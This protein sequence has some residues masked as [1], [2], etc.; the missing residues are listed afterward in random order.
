MNRN[1]RSR[2]ALTVVA[3]LSLH[4][5]REARLPTQA[6]RAELAANAATL[7][8]TS[9]HIVLF[10]AERV[11]ADFAERVSRLGGSVE[12]SLDGIG[13]ATVT[14]LSQAAAAEVAAGADVQ[15]M[16]PDRVMTLEAG[17]VEADA[18]ATELTGSEML[19]P[20]DATPSPT[21]AQFYPRQWNM[22]AV[23]ADRAW[24]AGHLGSRDVK[25]A[26][27]DTGIDYT[28]PDFEGLIDLDQS[29]SFVPEDDAI[30][31]EGYPGR[32]PISDLHGHGTAMASVIGSNGTRLAAVNQ[33]VTLLAVK[34]W[35]RSAEGSVARL[36][37]GVVYAA[38]HGADVI[39]VSGWYA[40]DKS[41]DHGIVAAVNRA[42]NY[43]FRK[44]AVFLSVAGNDAADLD[45]NGDLVV[46]P[47]EAPHVICASATGPTSN[48]GVNGP[49]V[50]V[51]AFVTLYSNYGRS[52]VD[53]AAPGGTGDFAN[54][55]RF[56]FGRVWAL[57]TTT[58]IETS[59]FRACMDGRPIVQ[60]FG[61]SLSAAHVS[62]LA[63]LLVAQLGHGNP[64]LIR[65]RI[66]QSA[67]DL[68]QPGTDPYYGKGRIN[69]ARALGVTP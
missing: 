58:V 26:I 45:H 62:G 21:A 8:Q 24:A 22:R 60:P 5:C 52:S 37:T 19:A 46:L 36:L 43:A 51:D 18:V 29:T 35:N 16:E 34:V 6:A 28:L 14:G 27:L 54:P 69:I 55:Q 32:L 47:C 67:D 61:T 50:D 3:A 41:K 2:F 33:N 63:A 65:E 42:A 1:L 23:F 7:D 25:V 49:W 38:D 4:A 39:N 30:I 9:R 20:A 59:T 40:F 57:C 15:A 13:A 12:A 11:P 68:G 31:A 56:Q 53:V 10:T 48:G 66:I 44:G 64:A 17:G